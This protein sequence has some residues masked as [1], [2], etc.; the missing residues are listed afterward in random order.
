MIKTFRDLEVYQEAYK[1]MIIIHQE[2]KK[3]PIYE[4]F[5]LASQM[6]RASKSIPTNI[7][8]GWTKRIHEKDFKR[9]LD[10]ALG[11]TNEMQVHVEI[12]KDLGYLNINLCEGL[13]NRYKILGS[14]LA[15]LRTN[16]KTF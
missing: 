4:R 6:R 1:L 14:R 10:I 12:A 3:F 11:S 9:Y 2:V 13:L 5:D 15:K 16:W 7:V 8:E